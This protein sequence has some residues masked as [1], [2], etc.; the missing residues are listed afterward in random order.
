M[1]Y[2]LNRYHMF[3]SRHVAVAAIDDDKAT[4]KLLP[5]ENRNAPDRPVWP[6]DM[7]LLEQAMSTG[8]SIFL[9][10]QTILLEPQT[11][12]GEQLQVFFRGARTKGHAMAPWRM[13]GHH[14][15]VCRVTP[16]L[17]GTSTCEQVLNAMGAV[18]QQIQEECQTMQET[19]QNLQ[20]EEEDSD[21]PLQVNETQIN[22]QHMVDTAISGAVEG[23][24]DSTTQVPLLLHRAVQ[25]LT[26][27]PAMGAQADKTAD[28][29]ALGVIQAQ[30]EGTPPILSHSFLGRVAIA[31]TIARLAPVKRWADDIVFKE[32]NDVAKNVGLLQQYMMRQSIERL[33]PTTSKGDSYDPTTIKA[34]LD[35]YTEQQ[36]EKVI[37]GSFNPKYYGFAT[38][39]Q[40]KGPPV[41]DMLKRAKARV[42]DDGCFCGDLPRPGNFNLSM[43]F[44][45]E[46]AQFANVIEDPAI[47]NEKPKM[48]MCF[49]N[50]M[51]Q[52]HYWWQKFEE[53]LRQTTIQQSIF[54]ALPWNAQTPGT[55]VHASAN[56]ESYI[57]QPSDPCNDHEC[58]AKILLVA[59]DKLLTDVQGDANRDLLRS[60][61]HTKWTLLFDPKAE[62]EAENSL[63]WTTM[64]EE[65]PQGAYS[66]EKVTIFWSSVVQWLEHQRLIKSTIPS[67]VVGVVS[68]DEEAVVE[69]PQTESGISFEDS[70]LNVFADEKTTMKI[71]L[72]FNPLSH[73]SDT[74]IPD[75]MRTKLD[76]LNAWDPQW[77]PSE[78]V[79]PYPMTTAS[80][81]QQINYHE[82]NSVKTCRTVR[83]LCTSLRAPVSMNKAFF[84]A[85][86]YVCDLCDDELKIGKDSVFVMSHLTD[87]MHE[88]DELD[89]GHMDD[90][91][92]LPLSKELEH[93]RA[94]VWCAPF[95]EAI[96]P[97]IWKRRITDTRLVQ[98]IFWTFFGHAQH[99]SDFSADKLNVA[100][101]TGTGGVV[102]LARTTDVTPGRIFVYALTQPAEPDPLYASIVRDHILELVPLFKALDSQS[103]SDALDSIVINDDFVTKVTLQNSSSSK[104][105]PNLN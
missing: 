65:T 30:G 101:A 91:E 42:G 103:V 9:V 10:T 41:T 52:A 77:V 98:H 62:A 36:E 71:A 6:I 97:E 49:Q 20:P 83:L 85:R 39:T 96:D 78:H 60:Y 89:E 73:L 43:G 45:K 44:G 53:E 40:T 82:N 31:Q 50:V 27:L 15:V 18:N 23:L 57:W 76:I 16:M 92:I 48:K 7:L 3:G 61:F 99:F 29:L 2:I 75:E 67:V 90:P 24:K 26:N 102:V 51:A 12:F 38:V 66:Q 14:V 86:K 87:S 81:A 54:M 47:D 19:L 33:L 80:W 4:P 56:L 25:S 70:T 17:Q 105:D 8:T 100:H 72:L 37:S 35:E 94:L 59:V 55:W 32:A 69:T 46:E 22:W 64:W 68:Y 84:N 88:L 21:A 95:G 104:E 28:A 74:G 63:T 93:A 13:V 1:V 5:I 79:K 11:E 34:L 58:L